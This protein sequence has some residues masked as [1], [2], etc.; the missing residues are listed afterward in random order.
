MRRYLPVLPSL[1]V[2]LCLAL[3][4]A[5]QSLSGR[6]APSFSLPNSA[7]VQ[8]DILDYRGKWLLLDFMQTT[9]PHCVSLT[10]T[11]EQVKLKYGNKVAILSVVLAPPENTQTVTKYAAENRVTHPIVFDQ[12]QVT[13]AYFK[14]TPQ[15]ASFDIP[16]LFVVDPRGTIVRDWAHSDQ[17]R[18]IFEGQALAAELERLM[19]AP[20]AKK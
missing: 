13:I 11:L 3:P 9:C 12:S 14:A 2:L 8:H 18:D 15:K 5:A 17:T 1:A 7:G 19:A 6:R 20:A 10:K 4:L 16:H